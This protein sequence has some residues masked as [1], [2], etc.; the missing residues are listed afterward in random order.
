MPSIPDTS[1]VP[2]S[3][4]SPTDDAPLRQSEE[5]F[6]KA[7]HFAPIPTSLTRI[8]DGMMLDANSS[9][10]DLFG[11]AREE[12]IGRTALELGIWQEEAERGLVL[13]TLADEGRVTDLQMR[14]SAKGGEVRD[15]LVSA[16]TFDLEGEPCMLSMAR[17]VTER[18]RAEEAL[19]QSEEKYRGLVENL[20]EGV[21]ATDKDSRTTFVNS[22][23]A[24]MLGYTCEEMMGQHLF[25]LM[26]E[27]GAEIARQ[28]IE[29]RR[30]G[31][32][33]QQDFEFL[34]KDGSRLRVTMAITPLT[35]ANGDYAGALAGM[36]DLTDRKAAEEA[37]QKSEE[38][39]RTLAA[40]APIGIM[41]IDNRDGLVYCNRRFLD[42]FRLPW[43]KSAGFGW[44]KS[45]HPDDRE[46]FLAHRSKAMAEGREFIREFRTV[47]LQGETRW[48]SV[49]TT[50]LLSQDGVS[51]TRVG[52]LEDIT[53]RRQAEQ[54]LRESEERF[55]TLAASAPSG[56]FLTDAEGRC[57]YINERLQSISGLT[58]E[59][60]EGFTWTSVVHPDDRERVL[61]AVNASIAERRDVD[62]E[63]RMLLPNE[64]VRWVHAHTG[65]V[66]REGGQIGR[67]GTVE[68][69]TARKLAE[70][71]LRES[72]RRFRQV[73]DVS[74]DMIYKLEL[75]SDTFDYISPSVLGMT[76]IT[77]E[78][79]IAM[80]PRR[81]RR[82]IHPEDWPDLRR[83]S[84]EFVELGSHPGF[85][86]RLQC[87]DGEYRWLSDNRALVRG[88]DGRPLALV[89]TVRNSLSA[90][91]ARR[92]CKKVFGF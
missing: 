61:A 9:L 81:L 44:V 92:S 54:A 41:L 29:R 37:L 45:L 36:L 47:T 70:Q 42:I 2:S 31:I 71:A 90:S 49:H 32:A 56:I 76:G 25:T 88:E 43:E 14:V 11:L 83:G 24:A 23:M 80:G 10:C 75:E 50:P 86:Y 18:K 69:I 48:L 66:L 46:T 62:Q 51:N 72:E 64:V 91:A 63:F 27:Q 65:P 22:R 67:V 68:D 60:S 17:D 85:E 53:E 33:E 8:S 16:V 55:R 21:W 89:G 78:E 57:N 15:V 84:E 1:T 26:D 59:E 34:R 6:S 5:R 79:F 4:G 7:F 82:R 28:G 30:R 39:F 40:S 73:L 20:H 38:R 87:K 12:I 13:K 19:R 58:P 3:C 35:D 77:P 74:S 52:T